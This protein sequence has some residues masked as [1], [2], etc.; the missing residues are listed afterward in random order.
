[1]IISTGVYTDLT[2]EDY[3]ADKHSISRSAL[4]DFNVTPYTYWAKHLNPDRPKK[5]ATPAMSFG[6]AFHTLILEPKLFNEQYAVLPEAV[7]LK[8]VGRE[9]YDNYKRNTEKMENSGKIILTQQEF[10]TLRAM[11]L[12]ILS[13]EKAMNLI[14]ES[15]IENS[16]FWQDEDSGL[17]VKARPDILHS[18]M[19]VDLKTCFDASPRSFQRSMMDGGYHI[20]GAIIREGVRVLED[21][22][23]DNVINICI[24]TKYPHNMGIYPIEKE[25]I[26]AGHIKFKQLLVDL[27]HAIVHNEF[28]DYGIQSI[29]LP[30]WA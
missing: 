6:T 30:S 25:A 21:N 11:E 8:D 27:K 19:I 15:R 28:I 3:H 29:G 16:F 5:D 9:I 13:N 2:S 10:N 24:E 1:M 18:N 17:I 20:Q 7:K 4:M 23:I 12:K 14:R 26:D 22:T